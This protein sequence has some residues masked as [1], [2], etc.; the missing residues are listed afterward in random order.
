[1]RK[2]KSK[3]AKG[4]KMTNN[5][6]EKYEAFVS[7]D[8]A[9]KKHEYALSC[10]GSANRET[11]SVKHA[12][13]DLAELINNWRI[14]FPDGYI[15]IC[16]EQSRGSLVYFLM[17]FDF[18]VLYP[19]NPVMIKNYRKAFYPS[20]AKDDPRDA[21]LLLDLLVFH[22]NKLRPWVPEPACVRKLDLLN[23]HRR[24]LVDTITASTNSL[25]AYL[26]TY[27]PQ[28]LALTG[29][30]DT[31]QACDFLDKW[32]NIES[33]KKAKRSQIEKFYFSHH[34]R[35]RELIAERIQ[36]VESAV[37]ITTD[38][39]ICS[40]Y[41]LTVKAVVAQLRVLLLSRNEFD[42][43]LQETF[44]Q[45]PEK[46]FYAALPGAGQIL[47]PRL[48]VL[49]GLNRS[50]FESA[51]EMQSFSGVA[52]V[53][54]TSGN[55][56]WVHWRYACS[57]FV[58]QSMVEFANHSRKKSIWAGAYYDSLRETGK[59]HQAALRAL[60]FKWLRILFRCWKDRVAYDENT[61]LIALHKR[62]SPLAKLIA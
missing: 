51:A 36:L 49:F 19:V 47:Q 16:L 7:L 28:A 5:V 2:T 9:D 52:P 20:G 62:R 59:S 11:G 38:Q 50:K 6:P 23:Q 61:Y 54:E 29:E 48:A 1:L 17:Q 34:S 26:K 55:H 40:V 22:R 13:E 60:A 3:R 45:Y 39:A 56:R 58:R 21:D 4:E 46:N 24:H 37:P 25:T 57:K 42:Q 31:L 53:T 12:P 32:P 41:Q 18:I 15:A 27:Y 33:L 44:S 10:P 30:L 43:Q 35:N 14:R 8:W